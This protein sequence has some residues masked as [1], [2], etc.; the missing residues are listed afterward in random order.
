MH[1]FGDNAIA[2]GADYGFLLFNSVD[3]GGKYLGDRTG[4]FPIMSNA[5]AGYKYSI[6]YPGEGWFSGRCNASSCQP[7]YCHSQLGGYAKWANDASVSY[8]AWYTQGFGCYMTGGASGGPVFQ[9][10][11]SQWYVVGVNS[12]VDFDKTYTGSTCTRPTGVC[13]QYS[14]NLWAPYFN[15]RVIDAWSTYRIA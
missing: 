10:V 3:T 1:A 2:N 4:Y 15:Q 14:K 5:P 11:G 8:G 12:Y 7:Y 6:G 9:Y 13:G